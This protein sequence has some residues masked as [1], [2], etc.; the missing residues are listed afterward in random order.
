MMLFNFFQTH[1]AKPGT[2][3]EIEKVFHSAAGARLIMD[4]NVGS[5]RVKPGNDADVI[6]HV[7][8]GAYV[9]DSDGVRDENKEKQLLEHD[10]V[11][12]SQ[13]G[14]DVVVKRA[15]FLP[16]RS[17]TKVQPMAALRYE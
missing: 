3:D 6:I 7:H 2:V 16:A 11:S 13:N 17:A 12:F 15:G 4:V 14:K 8:R 10:A 5:V 9:R 1:A